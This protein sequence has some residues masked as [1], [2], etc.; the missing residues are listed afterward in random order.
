[1]TVY[2]LPM[3]RVARS[4]TRARTGPPGGW[5]RWLR[6]LYGAFLELLWLACPP[7]GVERWIKA[8]ITRRG[9]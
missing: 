3:P 7:D 5:G 6:D 9:L 4:M 1:M 2:A 8:E